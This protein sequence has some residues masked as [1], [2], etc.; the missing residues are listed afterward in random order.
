MGFEIYANVVASGSDHWGMP[1]VTY[2]GSD[3]AKDHIPEAAAE[4]RSGATSQRTVAG[5]GVSRDSE[6]L[7]R[8]HRYTGWTDSST[9]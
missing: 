3:R 9:D 4:T 8:K 2:A 7:S 6:S 5:G 1:V